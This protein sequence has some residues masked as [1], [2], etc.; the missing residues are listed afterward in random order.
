MVELKKAQFWERHGYPDYLCMVAVHPTD[1]GFKSEY[2]F[3]IDFQT[4]KTTAKLYQRGERIPNTLVPLK[5]TNYI[6]TK[7]QCS[8]NVADLVKYCKDADERFT[9]NSINW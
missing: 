8:T 6:I 7:D 3:G 1:L 2:L 5:A 9:E 4:F